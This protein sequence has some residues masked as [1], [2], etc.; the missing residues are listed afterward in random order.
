MLFRSEIVRSQKF[1]SDNTLQNA[2]DE[3]IKQYL[4]TYREYLEPEQLNADQYTTATRPVNCQMIYGVKNSEWDKFV[5][6][7][8]SISRNYIYNNNSI[9]SYFLLILVIICF[10]VAI[11][12]PRIS[13]GNPWQ[14]L[15]I[16]RLPLEGIIVLII[17]IVSIMSEMIWR[18]INIAFGVEMNSMVQATKSSVFSFCLVYG[19]YLLFLTLMFLAVWYCGFCVRPIREMG[20]K[21][22]VKERSLIYRFFPYMKEKFLTTY[23]WFLHID[24]TKDAKRQILKIVLVNAGILFIISSLWF[25]GLPITIVYSVLLYFILKKYISDLQK[26]YGLLLGAMN[27]IAEGDLNVSIVDDLGVFETL[28]PQIIKIQRGFKNAVEEEVKSQRM[29]TE[30]ITNVSHDLKTPL[31]AIITYIGLLQE[32]NVTEEQRKEYLR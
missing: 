14:K 16:L 11:F 25:G 29:K 6:K 31:T 1:E 26:K 18:S 28:K 15:K 20:V 24:I 8:Y 23:D 13:K 22:F 10:V 9:M 3:R 5:D 2:Y 19:R 12:L 17:M 30:L 32:P 21:N 7:N 27:E 4:T